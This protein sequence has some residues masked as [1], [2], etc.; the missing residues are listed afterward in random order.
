[1]STTWGLVAA[2]AGGR[3]RFEPAAGQR[4]PLGQARQ[5]VPGPGRGQ[6]PVHAVRRQRIVHP[7]GDLARLEP[8]AERDRLA[9]GVLAGVGQRLLRR[10]VRGQAGLRRQRPGRPGDGEVHRHVTLGAVLLGQRRQLVG[11][12][13]GVIAERQNGPAGRRQTLPGQRAGPGDALDRLGEL[14]VSGRQCIGGQ[15]PLG[16]LQVHRHRRERVGED[17]VDVTGDPGPL[18]ERGRLVLGL[19]GPA[20]LGEH[21]LGL[22]GPD[23]ELAPGQAGGPQSDEGKRVP[24][25]RAG[26]RA[27]DQPGH[28]EGSHRLRRDAQRCLGAQVD[29]RAEGSHAANGD[30]GAVRR[31]PS[32]HA[33]RRPHPDQARD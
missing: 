13:C 11:Q 1:M 23:E 33:T 8:E 5:A 16:G 12:R 7:D 3:P 27:G 22:L 10:P 2:G 20:N 28:Q 14:G 25:Q 4:G 32:Q 15:Q 19:P 6:R 31:K 24:Q 29:R 30:G 26:R 18:G 21:A 9:G 17:I